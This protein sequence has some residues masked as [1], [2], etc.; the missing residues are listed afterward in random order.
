MRISVH[1]FPT[2]A[3]KSDYCKVRCCVRE[4]N[5][6]LNNIATRKQPFRIHAHVEH[7]VYITIMLCHNQH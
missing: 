1:L 3:C 5:V 4:R 2:Q 7:A 6:V